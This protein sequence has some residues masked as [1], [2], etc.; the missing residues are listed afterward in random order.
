M[1]GKETK[2]K[3][4]IVTLIIMSAGMLFGQQGIKLLNNVSESFKKTYFEQKHDYNPLHIGDMWQY[5][6]KDNVPHYVKTRIVGDSI[7]NTK[8]YFKK[9]YWLYDF[10]PQR[11]EFISWERNDSST[12][13]S[14]MLDFE[15]A[16]NNGDTLEE[17]PLDSLDLPNYAYYTSYKYSYRSYSSGY[18]GKKD[19]IIYDSSWYDVWGDTVL[20][21][22]V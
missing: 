8:K 1:M 12:D 22:T 13:N 19:V 6:L 4:I 7:I 10:Y 5:Y 14:Y 11:S 21:R 15:D 20:V 16:N 2:M 9:I 17:L 18:F 3:K